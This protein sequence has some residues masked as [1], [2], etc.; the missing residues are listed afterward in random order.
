MSLP[1]K[2]EIEAVSDVELE[3]RRAFRAPREIVFDAF[4]NPEVL[5][6]WMWAREA[7]LVK[8]QS[9]VRVGGRIRF[10]WDMGEGKLMGMTGAYLELDPPARIVH[11]EDFDEDWTDGT[12]TVTTLFEDHGEDTL[13][14]MTIKYP[15]VKGREMAQQSGMADGMAETYARLDSLLQS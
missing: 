3:V 9:D 15:S 2:L 11:R 13:V 5:G 8:C 12:T 6:R 14:V 10:E 7:P 1:F 4:V